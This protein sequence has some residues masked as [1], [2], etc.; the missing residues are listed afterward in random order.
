[1]QRTLIPALLVSTTMAAC[2]PRSFNAPVPANELIALERSALDRWSKG[3]PG[4]F[5]AIYADEITYFD[6]TRERR[7]EGIAAMRAILEPVAGKFTI[8]RYEILNPK[9]QG[10]GNVAVLTYNLVNYT[11]HADGTE[12]PLN[13]W[14][15]STVFR[16]VDG[17]WRVIHSHWS[18]T[19]PNIQSP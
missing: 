16:R 18:F 5:F 3:D 7:I 14:N 13:R 8:P 17:N 19:K 4:G 6:P 12:R 10:E 9:V 1:M 11:R 15:S 2:A